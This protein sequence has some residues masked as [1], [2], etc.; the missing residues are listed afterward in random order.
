LGQR[1]LERRDVAADRC[2]QHLP[3]PVGDPAVE[4]DRRQRSGREVLQLG[5]DLEIMQVLAGVAVVGLEVRPIVI[6]KVPPQGQNSGRGLR[7]RLACQ[8]L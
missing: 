6:A 5:K 2:P 1:R 7:L 8:R 4:N 3:E